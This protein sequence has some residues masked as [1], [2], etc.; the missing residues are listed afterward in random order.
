MCRVRPALEFD[1]VG[2]RR[3][4]LVTLVLRLGERRRDCVIVARPDNEQRRAIL[5]LE[6]NLGRR[7][8]VEVGEPRLIEDLS[9]LGNR[10]ARVRGSGVLL[11]E[12]VH[13][14]YPAG[15]KSNQRRIQALGGSI[16][17][18]LGA[19]R[20][21]GQFVSRLVGLLEGLQGQQSR[22]REPVSHRW[23]HPHIWRSPLPLHADLVST[24]RPLVI[25]RAH[26]VGMECVVFAVLLV[27]GGCL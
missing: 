20:A 4:T 17:P 8:Q 25:P 1:V 26:S 18:R 22:G 21:L 11:G 6:V 27:G 19:D 24:S 9:R 7:V 23:A 10:I 16:P 2:L 14:H 13:E 15:T 12:G 5:I 3:R